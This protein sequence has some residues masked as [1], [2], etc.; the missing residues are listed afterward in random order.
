MDTLE[1]LL[2]CGEEV[3]WRS[4]ES[5]VDLPKRFRRDKIGFLIL[6]LVSFTILS[7]FFGYFLAIPFWVMVTEGLTNNPWTLLK[8]SL[9]DPS[10][11]FAPA[12]ALGGFVAETAL[13]VRNAVAEDFIA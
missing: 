1:E 11:S 7:A 2:T 8:F 12:S 4:V 5:P 13:L 3:L 6:F 9:A 10:N